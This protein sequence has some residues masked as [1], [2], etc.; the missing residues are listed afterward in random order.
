MTKKTP[1]SFRP[2]HPLSVVGRSTT[3]HA[4][5]GDVRR[6][7]KKRT[8]RG[9][10]ASEYGLIAAL[11][12]VVIIAATTV[13]GAQVQWVGPKQVWARMKSTMTR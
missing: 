13:M 6:N 4:S 5:G 11:V 7:S 8:R 3:A 10:T 2:G 1:L 12:S 9:A